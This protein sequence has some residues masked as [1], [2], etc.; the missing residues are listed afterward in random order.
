MTKLTAK[1]VLAVLAVAAMAVAGLSVGADGEPTWKPARAGATEPSRQVLWGVH[2][3]PASGQT[4]QQSIEALESKVGRRFGAVREYRTWQSPF[5]GRYDTWLRDSGH[6]IL[7]SVLPKRLDGSPIPWRN[8]ANA[9]PGWKL[10][11]DMVSWANKL[12]AY[13][14]PIELTFHHEPETRL[15]QV[16]GTTAEFVAAWRK[17]VSVLRAQGVTNARYLWVMTDYS[18]AAPTWDRRYATK[19]YPGDAWVDDMGIDAYNWY[20]CR[21]DAP[22]GWLSLRAIVEKFRVFGTQH[23]TK[24]LYLGEWASVED[25]SA[26]NRKAAWLYDTRELLK[27]PGYE[28]FRGLVYYNQRDGVYSGCDWRVDSSTASLA[29]VRA[30]GADFFYR[31]GLP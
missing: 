20:R 23:P 24:G 7:L 18:F 26:P 6:R 30:M 17:V 21:P 3:L 1:A 28:Q 27:Q 29:A 14:A 4:A 11:N 9:Q 2:A 5:P 15:N 12:K 8:I 31:A 19:W 10:Y 25:P 22:I 16:Y 13:G